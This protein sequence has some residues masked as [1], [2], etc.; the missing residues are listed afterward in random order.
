MPLPLVTGA[1]TIS[2]AG[3]ELN[4]SKS[5]LA[6]LLTCPLDGPIFNENVSYT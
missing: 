5:G 2:F 4:G 1:A 3:S 6:E